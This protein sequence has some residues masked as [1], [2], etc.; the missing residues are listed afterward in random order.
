MPPARPS[1]AAA[2]ASRS[3]TRAS[4]HTTTSR[5]SPATPAGCASSR[6][7]DFVNGQQG[8][9]DDY[10]HG[11]HVAGIIAGNGADSNGTYAGVAPGASIVSLK[12]LDGEGHGTISGA[13]AAIEYAIA[14]AR[15]LNLRVINLSIGAPVTESAETDP[16]TARGSRRGRSR[17]RGGGV[18]R[19]LRQDAAGVT[20]Y[21]A[22]TAP[23]NAP[24]VL[25]VGSYTSNGTAATDDDEVSAFS[26]RGPTLVDLGAKPDLVA[27]G[28]RIVSLAAPGSTLV[29]PPA[30]RTSSAGPT[31]R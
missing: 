23:G 2:C 10:G 30:R 21:G 15:R 17:D 25:T 18:G 28:S 12:V 6:P 22:I 11:T 13:I 14:N 16:L 5:P 24:W 26:S 7:S 19:Q 8:T 3:S 4:P 27:P 9:Y 31:S 1:T 29:G 20:Q